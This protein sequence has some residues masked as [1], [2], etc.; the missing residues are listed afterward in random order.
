MDCTATSPQDRCLQCLVL[1]FQGLGFRI[2]VEGSRPC[3]FKFQGTE[4]SYSHTLIQRRLAQTPL[5]QSIP[6]KP[7]PLASNPG[8]LQIPTRNAKPYTLG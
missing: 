3:E 7:K 8:P 6:L 4:S 1:G 5:I 2:E